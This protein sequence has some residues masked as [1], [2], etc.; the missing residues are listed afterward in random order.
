MRTISLLVMLVLLMS[1]CSNENDKQLNK[2]FLSNLNYY[3]KKSDKYFLLENLRLLEINSNNI[4]KESQFRFHTLYA[5]LLSKENRADEAIY[6]FEKARYLSKIVEKDLTRSDLLYLIRQYSWLRRYVEAENLIKTEFITDKMTLRDSILKTHLEEYFYY[7]KQE[8]VNALRKNEDRIKLIKKSFVDDSLITSFIHKADY[9]FMLGE[10]E[11]S[12]SLMDSLIQNN[13]IVKD[14]DLIQLYGSYGVFQFYEE[15]YEK[16]SFY[17]K[18]ALKL[19]K[20]E[21]SNNINDIATAYANLAEVHIYLKNLDKTKKYIDSF[22]QLD[23]T[24]VKYNLQK[25][26]LKYNYLLI[27]E[28]NGDSREVLKSLDKIAD[29]QYSKYEEKTRDELVAMQLANDY[30]L[31][32]NKQRVHLEQQ[33]KSAWFAFVCV[34]LLLI[35]IALVFAL[36][37]NRHKAK[38]IKRVSNLEQKVF[39]AQIKPH[40]LYN[41]LTSIQGYIYNEPELASNLLVKF[42]RLLRQVLEHSTHE[43]IPIEEELRLLQNY[44]DVF[45]LRSEQNVSFTVNIDKSLGDT[46]F[47]IPPMLLQPFVENSIQHAFPTENFE[48]KILISLLKCNDDNE[49]KCIIEDNGIGIRNNINLSKENKTSL[50]IS[51]IEQLLKNKYKSQLILNC[52]KNFNSGTRVEFKLPIV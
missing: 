9:L 30:A 24:Q 4:N 46:E 12:L 1:S 51:M 32:M 49:L 35:I 8:Y 13:S 16:A 44:I 15:D 18:E 3:Q 29:W 52:S 17:Y 42:S 50:S 36:V 20:K 22:Y 33:R 37:Y 34:L 6:H 10:R 28:T 45:N 11:K 23:M 25:S 47:K 48:A 7:Q 38:Y 39:A 27:E 40:F 26:V 21:T 19:S 2:Q 5:R 43:Y 14:S 31:K 41:V